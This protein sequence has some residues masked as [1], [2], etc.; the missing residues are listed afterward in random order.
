MFTK[1]NSYELLEL[2][3]SEPIEENGIDT[4]IF[5]Y[6]KIDS[7]LIK[8]VLT[9]SIYQYECILGLSHSTTDMV[10]FETKINDVKELVCKKDLLIIT[11][12][13]D[14]N[15]FIYFKPNFFIKIEKC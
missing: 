11:R 9:L 6:S 7:S 15:I 1:Y 2:F 5:I 14:D 13:N 4:G 8:C 10:I 3:E 12:K